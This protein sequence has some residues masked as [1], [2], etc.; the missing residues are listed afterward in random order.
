MLY[1]WIYPFLLILSGCTRRIQVFLILTPVYYQRLYVIGATCGCC[2]LPSS[3]NPSLR[4][5]SKTS[6]V[7]ALSGRPGRAEQL[8]HERCQVAPPM[9]SLLPV[10][11]TLWLA[12]RIPKRVP[13]LAPSS[14]QT[15]IKLK[16]QQM[17]GWMVLIVVFLVDLKILNYACI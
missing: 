15:Y 12:S 7:A 11:G 8:T 10:C 14:Q 1:T 13:L 3:P 17:T 6:R 9:A 2:A 4:I 16:R 5:S